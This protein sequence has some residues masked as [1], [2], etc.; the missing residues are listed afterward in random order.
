MGNIICKKK[1]SGYENDNNNIIMLQYIK[2][3]SVFKH[4]QK[5]ISRITLDMSYIMLV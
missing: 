3:K 2:R 5:R 4:P 1:E